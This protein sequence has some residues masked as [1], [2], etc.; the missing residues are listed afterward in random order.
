[1]YRTVRTFAVIVGLGLAANGCGDGVTDSTGDPLTQEE[2]FAIYAELQ[3][4]VSDALSAQGSAAAGSGAMLVTP[5][6]PVTGSCGGG[7]TVTVT[8]DVDDNIDPQSGLG[9]ISFTLTETVDD[10]I[11]QTTGANFTVNGSPN[12]VVAGDLTVGE[13]SLGGTYDMGGGFAYTSDDGRAGTCGVD[14]SLNFSNL[15]VGGTICG[16]RIRG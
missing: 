2:A 16:K 9:T 4:A 1:M 8:G 13:N 5:I 14:V 15:S 11:V 3:F 7:G 10:C 6:T 12:I